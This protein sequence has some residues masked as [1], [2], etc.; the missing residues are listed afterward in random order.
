MGVTKESTDADIKKAYRKLALKWHP[1]KN[2][3]TEEQKTKAEKMFKEVNEAYAVLSDKEKR[4][5]H[6]MG[7][8]L[9]D[10]TNGSGG[11]GGGGFPG[12]MNFNMGGPGGGGMGG[13]DPNEIFKMFFS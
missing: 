7:F 10:M 5:Q 9:D 12:G 8:S 6:D 2:S 3:E 1:D 4:R 13:I 11:M